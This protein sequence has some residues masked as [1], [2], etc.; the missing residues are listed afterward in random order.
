MWTRSTLFLFMSLIGASAW[1]AEPMS[2]LPKHVQNSVGMNFVLIPA[3][4]FMMGSEESPESL[5]KSFPQ[6]ERE[7]LLKL[8]DEAPV[9]KVRITHAFYLGQ[10]EVTVGQFRRFLEASGYK[11]ESDQKR[12]APEAMVTTRTM[13][14]PHRRQVI[15]SRA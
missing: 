8:G 13:T 9:H 12:M 11:P 15:R 10:H 2:T 3:G 5:A 6:C 1:S 4:E 14:P 7:R